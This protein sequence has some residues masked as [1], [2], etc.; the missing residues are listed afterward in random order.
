[1]NYRILGNTGIKVSEIGFGAWGI[2]GLTK[3]RSS[4]G[5]TDDNESKRALRTALEEGITFYDTS[6]MYGY[7]H[8]EEL[9]GEVFESLRDKVIIATKVGFL[10]H[11]GPQDF[12]PQ[13][14][15]N[16]LEKSLKRLKTDYVDVYQLHSPA[17]EELIKRPENLETF[18]KLQREGKIRAIGISVVGPTDGV[19][20]VKEFP[21][22]RVIQTNLNLID[23]RALEIG[24]LDLAEQQHVGIIAR[25]PLCFGFLADER[26]QEFHP[27]DHRTS[28]PPE[29][30]KRWQSAPDLFMPLN[31]GK[32]RT[33]AQLALQFCLSQKA[34]ASV[35]P[36]MTKVGRV[37]ENATASTL[38]P[39]NQHEL[40][41]IQCIYMSQA[42]FDPSAR[43]KTL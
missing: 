12:S 18:I 8:S 38:G 24:L 25:T 11:L 3:G 34:V 5:P 33:F 20:V 39:L 40:H 27:R 14:V 21:N 30:L 1:M 9:I 35:I 19:R 4:Y 22:V 15:R 28:R 13:N 41:K 7:G 36:G 29:Q 10:E 17:I 31:K 43:Q 16:A 32:S 23:Q 37:I 42:F 2:G 26:P 6:D